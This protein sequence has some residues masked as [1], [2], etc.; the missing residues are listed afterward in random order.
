V[1]EMCEPVT[2][3]GILIQGPETVGDTQLYANEIFRWVEL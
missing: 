1:L 3:W 2:S